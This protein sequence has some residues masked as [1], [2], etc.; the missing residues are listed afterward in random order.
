MIEIN[1]L[2][3]ELRKKRIELPNIFTN[4]SFIPIVVF[5][6][7]V[8]L[9]LVFMTGMKART[10]AR[11]EKKWQEIL[12]ENEKA[13]KLKDELTEM[14]RKIDA[15]DNLIQGRMS[16]AKKLSDLSDAIIPGVWL[17]RLWLEQKTVLQKVVPKESEEGSTSVSAVPKK[18]IAETLHLYG[19]VIASGGEET[20]AIGK[21]IR[22]LKNSKGYFAD[23]KEIEATSIQRSRLKD[24]E[25]MDFELIC[26]FK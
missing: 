9:L 5:I 21:F 15:V 16:W 26:Y 20:A 1:L 14:R 18:T 8:H 3:K 19:S 24:V 4:I 25:V 10:L 12:P 2:P 11:Y 13:E 6:L 22:S 7:G 23:F 17:N